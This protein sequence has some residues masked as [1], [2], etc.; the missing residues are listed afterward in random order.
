MTRFPLKLL[1]AA[2]ALAAVTVSSLASAQSTIKRPGDRTPYS[3]EA[4]PHLLLGPFD[5]RGEGFGVGFRGTIEVAPRGFIKTI[6][7]S[8]GVGFGLDWVHYPAGAVRGICSRRV[9]GPNGTVICTEV[10]HGRDDRNYFYLPI[11]MQWNFWLHRQWSVF[12]EPGLLPYFH[13]S[14]PAFGPF[15]LSLYA[16]GRFHFSDRAT[17]TM[18][19][20]YPTMSVGVSFLL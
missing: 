6:N 19:I 15:P 20:G 11:V 18:R 14:H 12:G 16:G 4:E 8:V 1:A 2:S 13:G 9:Q 5:W 3:F 10:D 7:N 17:L